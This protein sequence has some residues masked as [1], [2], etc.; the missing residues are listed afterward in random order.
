MQRLISLR[1][2]SA[3]SVPK[4]DKRR[5]EGCETENANPE[6]QTHSAKGQEDYT[7]RQAKHRAAYQGAANKV[8][9]ERKARCGHKPETQQ[10]D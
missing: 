3:I 9:H 4:I 8:P 7:D 10:C 1:P 2:Q 5:Q 6:H